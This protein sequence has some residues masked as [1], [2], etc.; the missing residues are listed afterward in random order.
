VVIIISAV[1]SFT[2]IAKNYN[3]ALEPTVKLCQPTNNK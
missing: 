1:H 2:D 3:Y